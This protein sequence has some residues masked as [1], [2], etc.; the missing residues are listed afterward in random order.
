MRAPS[1]NRA[2]GAALFGSVL[3]FG[4]VGLAWTPFDPFALDFEA[5]LVPASAGHW[6]GTDEFGRDVLSRLLSATGV[7]L[8][9][10]AATVAGALSLGVLLGALAAYF[11]GWSDRLVVLCSDALMAFPGL[12]LALGLMAA[13][14][15]NR[16]GVVAALSLAYAPK[17]IRV[18]R[19]A[20][21]SVSAREFVLASR[22][23]GNGELFTILRHVI[24]N[25]I[26]PLTI[27]ATT[28]FGNALLS[29]TALSFLGL[30]VPPPESS[31]GGMM[32]DGRQYLS[33]AP[34][35]VVLPGLVVSLTLLGINLLGDALRDRFDPRMSGP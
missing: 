13:I 5:R 16:W 9:V 23:L 11:R 8:I 29:E 22:A 12:L 7:S 30:G 18:T 6:F 28:L 32:A 20:A 17:V 26:S 25:C 31:L 21:L 14:G 10:A 35:L 1:L 34:R 4:L 3:A 15:P 19:A 27:V 33:E 2:I 24:P